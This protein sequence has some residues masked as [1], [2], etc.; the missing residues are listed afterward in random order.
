MIELENILNEKCLQERILWGWFHQNLHT[1]VKDW[2]GWQNKNAKQLL[3]HGT[4]TK[5]WHQICALFW[6]QLFWRKKTVLTPRFR[7]QRRR[8]RQISN[9]LVFRVWFLSVHIS[10]FFESWAKIVEVV[11]LKIT[12][13]GTWVE[14]RQRSAGISV[15][16][17]SV[18][19]QIIK[20]S[21]VWIGVDSIL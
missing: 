19:P 10:Q 18:M 6:R 21:C 11:K 15:A 12:I 8:W 1:S 7:W 16:F 17:V 9:L 5:F 20:W 14:W 13:T 4:M 3:A 2:V